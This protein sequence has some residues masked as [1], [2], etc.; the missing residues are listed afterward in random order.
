MKIGANTNE[1]HDPEILKKTK[2]QNKKLLIVQLLSY[3]IPM[4]N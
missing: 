3:P 2:T 4:K 1:K